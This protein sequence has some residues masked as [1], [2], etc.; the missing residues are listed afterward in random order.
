[1]AV[2]PFLTRREVA[3][4]FEVSYERV[5]QLEQRGVIRAVMT[6]GARRMPLFDAK[7]VEEVRR[8]RRRGAA[9]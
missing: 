7:T 6:V 1:M 9:A 2:R 8:A 3:T 5:R 4:L